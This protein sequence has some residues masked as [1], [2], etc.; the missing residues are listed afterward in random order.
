[1]LQG[2]NKLQGNKAGNAVNTIFINRF[3]ERFENAKY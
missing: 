2:E 1:M 3:W